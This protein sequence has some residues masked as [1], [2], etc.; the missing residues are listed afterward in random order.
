MLVHPLHHVR[1]IVN[2]TTLRVV[3]QWGLTSV[4]QLHKGLQP[5][6]RR[7]LLHPIVVNPVNRIRDLV[8]DL[9]GSLPYSTEFF[10]FFISVL[11]PYPV[12]VSENRGRVFLEE[13]VQLFFVYCL[14]PFLYLLPFRSHPLN[15]LCGVL[16][17]LT[18]NY[19]G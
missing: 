11:D 15:K 19:L 5:F 16:T 18:V 12:T 6:D 13:I 4:M 17:A 14:Q 1:I 10:S 8:N 9:S 3:R 7:V 2:L